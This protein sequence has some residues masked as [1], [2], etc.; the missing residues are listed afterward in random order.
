MQTPPLPLATASQPQRGEASTM[1]VVQSHVA[2]LPFRVWRGGI[3][4]LM[5]KWNL[6]DWCSI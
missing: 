4:V 3:G 6:G 5:W 1:C 2:L